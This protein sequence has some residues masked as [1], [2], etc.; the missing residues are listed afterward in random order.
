MPRAQ[1]KRYFVLHHTDTTALLQP[2]LAVA[3]KGVPPSALEQLGD[4]QLKFFTDYLKLSD[5]VSC[6]VYS[7]GTRVYVNRGEMPA[8][9]DGVTVPAKGFVRVNK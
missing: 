1:A 4:L 9:Y 2:T 5:E 6:S 7:D 3:S 8:E